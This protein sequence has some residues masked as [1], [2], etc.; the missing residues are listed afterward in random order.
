MDYKL[1]RSW[2][3]SRIGA[4]D[5]GCTSFY[6]ITC[7]LASSVGV[8][9]SQQFFHDLNAVMDEAS[10]NGTKETN[11]CEIALQLIADASSIELR[12][13]AQIVRVKNHC[14]NRCFFFSERTPFG[15]LTLDVASS[16]SCARAWASH[17]LPL[18]FSFSFIS[19]NRIHHAFPIIFL[20]SLT[21][22]SKTFSLLDRFARHSSS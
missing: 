7:F 19:Q 20:S 22:N 16:V 11:G 4:F 8:H 9:E 21:I 10:I 1:K 3:V 5:R 15:A 17:V 2:N 12:I 18:V 13:A 6:L 14:E